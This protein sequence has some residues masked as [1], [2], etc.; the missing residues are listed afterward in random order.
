MRI[1]SIGDTHLSFGCPKPK[2]MHVFGEN[3]RNHYDQIKNNWQQIAKPDDLLIIAGDISWALRFNEVLPDLE[4]IHSE[5]PGKK[6]LIFG[7]HDFWFKSKTKLNKTLETYDS[8][9]YLDATYIIENDIAVIGG[10]GWISPGSLASKDMFDKLP[11]N[12]EFKEPFTDNDMK[13]YTREYNNLKKAFEELKNSNQSYKTLILALHYPAFNPQQE[14]SLFTS[15]IKEYNV[16]IFINGHLHGQSIDLYGFTGI[17]ENCAYH[18]VSADS[19]NFTP[20][21]IL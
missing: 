12:R 10:R 20:K 18:L 2:P 7:N 21:Q 19:I 1:F 11:N 17:K 6:I 4:W 14:D 3:W 15:L 13:I 16:N 8:I 5:L 9:R